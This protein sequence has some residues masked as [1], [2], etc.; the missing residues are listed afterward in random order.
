MVDKSKSRMCLS[1]GYVLGLLGFIRLCL[2]ELMMG[3]VSVE[4]RVV[5]KRHACFHDRWLLLHVICFQLLSCFKFGTL[6]HVKGED[7]MTYLFCMLQFV[8]NLCV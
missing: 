8:L 6:V 1:Q 2:A 3:L 4:T 5:A 7:R